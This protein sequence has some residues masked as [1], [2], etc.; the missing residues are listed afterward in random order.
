[1]SEDFPKYAKQGFAKATPKM[2]AD[3]MEDLAGVSKNTNKDVFKKA[4]GDMDLRLDPLFKNLTQI[5]SEIQPMK[6]E[7]DRQHSQWTKLQK[8][9]KETKKE[10]EKMNEQLQELIEQR[11]RKRT[12]SEAT[13]TRKRR[14]Q[15]FQAVI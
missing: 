7:R 14:K 12:C 4:L 10:L 3:I 15:N 5:E 11:K 6:D 13:E 1:M 2:K 9:R 8:H